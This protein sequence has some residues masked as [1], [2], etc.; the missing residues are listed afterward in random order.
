M[1]IFQVLNMIGG[2][3]LFLYGMH[4]MGN[5][6]SKMAGGKLEGVLEK[7]TSKR[8]FAVLLGA[9][10]TAVIQSS[11]ATTVM[12]VGFVNSGIM[13]LSQAVGIIMGANVGTTVTS[14]L[15]S[16]TSID[17]S[18]IWVQLLK[19]S[20]FS[21]ILAAVG[22]IL[23]MSGKGEDRRKDIGGILL[24]FAVLMFGM[25]TMSDSVSGLAENAAFTSLMTTFSNPFLGMLMGAIL[26]A[27]IQSSSASVGILQALC[28][29]GAVPYGVALPIIMGQ[30][31]GT[32]VTSILSSVGASKNAR[33]AAMIHLY[34]NLIGTIVFMVV[35]YGLHIWI[36]FAFLHMAANAAG[37]ALIHSA[38]NIGATIL[39]YPLANQ[40]VRLA[41]WTIP[42][43]RTP[44]E[45]LEV[46]VPKPRLVIDERFLA[47][48]S[49]AVEIC[50]RYMM[51]LAEK[52]KEALRISTGVLLSYD[53]VG[54]EQVR[55]LETEIDS[56]EDVL[57]SYLVKLSTKSL[58]GADSRAVTGML[59]SISN[60]ERIS[61][62]AKNLV[63]SAEEMKNKKLKFSKEAK[64]EMEVLCRA[65]DDIVTKTTA[66]YLNENAEDAVHVEPLEEVIDRLTKKIKNRHVKRLQKGEC[67]I[68]MGLI[69]EDLLLNLE[70]VSDHCSNI[71]MELMMFS[72]KASDTH[73]YLEE[74]TEEQRTAFDAEYQALKKQYSLKKTS[75]KMEKEPKKDKKK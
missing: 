40:L 24:G 27:I 58:S 63:E 21:P 37:I 52:S 17:G 33:R 73:D 9:G 71:A 12:V 45:A 30:N 14:W 25:E 32:C 41:E 48:P 57:G 26:T 43:E 67:S 55:A 61:D 36:D 1:D 64:R 34:F 3:A 15:L 10:V 19:P 65:V 51:E 49:F 60:F 11:S 68:E 35:F 62:H 44:Q 70:R 28:A 23:L 56:Y 5:G 46:S 8:I 53:A 4:T 42:D 2:L 22:I 72:G 39:L 69:L 47:K 16:L 50:R 75:D 74:M 59:H 31:I 54:A 66:D 7:L 13:K 20:S 6:L 18:S 29:T 38:F